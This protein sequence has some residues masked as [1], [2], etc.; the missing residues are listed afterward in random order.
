MKTK[1]KTLTFKKILFRKGSPVFQ[2]REENTIFFAETV[3]YGNKWYISPNQGFVAGI[4][5]ISNQNGC[6]IAADEL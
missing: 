4:L 2:S 5:A 6:I 3:Q 1:E